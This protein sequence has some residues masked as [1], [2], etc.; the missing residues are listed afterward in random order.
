MRPCSCLLYTSPGHYLAVIYNYDT[1]VV[2]VKGEDSYETI[3]A[4]TGNC[5]GLGDSET[6]NMVWGPDNFYAVSYTHLKRTKAKGL[7]KEKEQRF[8]PT[9]VNLKSNTMKKIT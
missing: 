7:K 4:C 8:A 9:F 5:T 1:E 6:E 3:M 2:Q